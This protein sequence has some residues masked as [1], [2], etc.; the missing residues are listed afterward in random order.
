MFD[1]INEPNID[2]RSVI[3]ES[4]I[5]KPLTQLIDGLANRYKLVKPKSVDLTIE[6]FRSECVNH[7]LKIIA[8][9]KYIKKEVGRPFNYLTSAVANHIIGYSKSVYKR[10]KIH[11]T[12]YFNNEEFVFQGNPFADDYKSEII[13]ESELTTSEL[14]LLN[15]HKFVKKDLA[16]D[17]FRSFKERQFAE[18]FII[19]LEQ[20]LDNKVS[21]YNKYFIKLLLQEL[22]GFG[23]SK[24]NY[25]LNQFKTK[26]YRRAMED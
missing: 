9:D 2:T 14:I 8:S 13:L 26:Y 11:E 1:Y 24:V 25:Y 17:N 6:A 3:F 5:H 7:V 22:T 16:D 18:G 15:V 21:W 19:M 23:R 12:N 10:K 20:V 4:K